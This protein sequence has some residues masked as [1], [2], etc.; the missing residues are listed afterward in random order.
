MLVMEMIYKVSY[1]NQSLTKMFLIQKSSGT[2]DFLKKKK[3]WP[4]FLPCLL[5]IG[6]FEVRP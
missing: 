4:M 6:Y 1:L 3:Y 5:R 2:L